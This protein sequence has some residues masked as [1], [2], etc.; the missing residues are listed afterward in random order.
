MG[1]GRSSEGGCGRVIEPQETERHRDNCRAMSTTNTTRFSDRVRNY[2]SYRPSYPIE[3]L[4]VLRN[5]TGLKCEH[6]IADIGS[7]TGISSKLFLNGGHSV[8]AVEPNPEMREAAETLLSNNPHFFSIN[9]TAEAT[10]L[11]LSSIDYVVAAQAFHWFNP[12]AVAREWIR[13][14][15]PGGWIVLLW[16]TRHTDTTP[17]LRAYESLLHRYSTDYAAVNHENVSDDAIRLVLGEGYK[18]RVVPNQQVFDFEGLRGRLL[19][20]SYAPNVG[21]PNYL[22]MLENLKRIFDENQ[23]NGCVEFDYNTEIYFGRPGS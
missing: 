20:S 19:S 5:E 6:V 2:V 22:P 23:V 21:H 17:F 18:R 3:V 1:G 15:K 7:G 12:E 4:E 13:V 10:T 8:F 11:P 9:G 14:L 16:N